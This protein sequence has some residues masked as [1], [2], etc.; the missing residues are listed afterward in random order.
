SWREGSR[1]G[2]RS[3]Q[4]RDQ[5]G[6]RGHG[7]RG[8]LP[9]RTTTV[10]PSSGVVVPCF[11]CWYGGKCGECRPLSGERGV[12]TRK[13]LL[14]SPWPCPWVAKRGPDANIVLAVCCAFHGPRH[15]G[16]GPP[17]R[18]RSSVPSRG[19]GVARGRRPARR[20]LPPEP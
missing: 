5:E 19:A 17:R 15:G 8:Y 3:V 13:C 20:R 11:L 7:E 9:G 6:F 10:C 4:A 16:H 18:V 1:W 12:R 2:A 14:V